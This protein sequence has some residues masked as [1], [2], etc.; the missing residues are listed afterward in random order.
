MD[1]PSDQQSSSPGV[2]AAVAGCWQL[3][4]RTALSLYPLQDSVLWL[5]RGRAWVTL[6]EPPRGQGTDAGDHFLRAG[7]RLRIKAGCH[8]VLESFDAQPVYFD[9]MSAPVERALPRSRWQETVVQPLRDFVQ[10]LWLAGG[11]LRRLLRGLGSYGEFLIAGRGRVL[12]GY[13][14]NP[15]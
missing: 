4:P 1:M 10:A 7:D 9:W 2:G 14:A 5:A 3:R 13:E 8:L 6:G 11:A 12:S 15:P